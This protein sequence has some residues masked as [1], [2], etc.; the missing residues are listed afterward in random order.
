MGRPKGSVQKKVCACGEGASAETIVWGSHIYRPAGKPEVRLVYRTSCCLRGIK[1]AR[2]QRS[3]AISHGGFRQTWWRAQQALLYLALNRKF[4]R[5]FHCRVNSG[6]GD[7]ISTWLKTDGR[8]TVKH[9]SNSTAHQRTHVMCNSRDQTTGEKTDETTD[10]ILHRTMNET[11]ISSLKT[12]QA[13][14]S[15]CRGENLEEDLIPAGI[16][17]DHLFIISVNGSLASCAQGAA[18][19]PSIPIRSSNQPCGCAGQTDVVVR[20]LVAPIGNDPGVGGSGKNNDVLCGCVRIHWATIGIS[21]GFDLNI[22]SLP[23]PPP[24]PPPQDTITMPNTSPHLL[25]HTFTHTSQHTLQNSLQHNLTQRFVETYSVHQN[26][27]Q[28]SLALHPLL[29]ASSLAGLYTQADPEGA[30]Y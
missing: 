9:Q 18:I 29:Q 26:P 1:S 2:K 25:S 4:P 17:A 7:P 28:Q 10:E 5:H 8:K 19:G 15:D 30:A 23:P 21:S 20:E 13:K 22:S 6:C 3:F 16:N 24:T 11:S 14:E 12:T 27:Y